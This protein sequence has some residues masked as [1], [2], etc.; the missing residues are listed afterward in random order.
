MCIVFWTLDHPDYSLII[1][2]NRDEFLS[3]PTKSAHFHS[4]NQ[5][6]AAENSILSGIDDVGGGTWFGM[7]R[8]G[9]VALL[10][11][12]TESVATTFSSSRGSLVS[13]FLLSSSTSPSLDDSQEGHRISL[14]DQVRELYPRDAKF[15]G[16]NML[17]LAPTRPSPGPGPPNH[18]SS[19]SHPSS[20]SSPARSDRTGVQYDAYFVTN[21]GADGAISSRPLT[22]D[23][24]ACGGF[25][26]GVDASRDGE[27]SDWPKVKHGM[28]DFSDALKH[29][30]NSRNSSSDSL[31]L[32]TELVDRLFELLAWKSPDPITA[33]VHLRNT[34]EVVPIP[35]PISKPIPNPSSTPTPTPIPISLEGETD[36]TQAKDKDRCKD[37]NERA[38]KRTNMNTDKD[39]DKRY[40]GTRL[41]TVILIRRDTGNVTFIERDIWKLGRGERGLDRNG[42]MNVE[43]ERMSVSSESERRFC[44]ELE[45]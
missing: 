34:V 25:S 9:R 31:N 29:S 13:S 33:R 8:T 17:L 36:A 11:N 10:T 20:T 14:G 39:E 22:A 18:P 37:A 28:R 4:F 45:A 1:C 38:D 7:S 30:R 5:H 35:I 24:K 15:A 32:E 42:D 19:P 21:A 16:F 40:Y 44:F 41:A 43:V 2:S 6:E 27:G 3:R 26:N 12:I 23:E